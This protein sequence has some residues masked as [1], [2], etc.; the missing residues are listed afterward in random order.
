MST[1]TVERKYQFIQTSEKGDVIRV[2]LDRPPLNVLDVAMMEELNHALAAIS[3]RRDL[4]ALV[5]LAAGKAFSAGVSVEDHL[6]DQARSMLT[7]FHQIFRYLHS[8]PCVT[9]AVVQGMALGGGAELATFFDVV[10]ASDVARLGQ[11]E[12]KVGVFPPIAA[13]HYPNRIGSA[14]TL[15]LLLSGETLTAEEALRIGLVDRVVKPDALDDALNEALGKLID[16]SGVVLAL[17]RR[18]VKQATAPN[19]EETLNRLETLYHDELMKTE[20]ANEGLRAFV[21]KRQP[22]WN[23]R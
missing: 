1:P 15:Q 11:P 7:T 2:V 5:L 22:V 14:R 6:G 17:T 4:K 23:N 12:I 13:L 19:F 8:L 9:V 3:Q 20:D 10:I 18:A 16:K 21:E